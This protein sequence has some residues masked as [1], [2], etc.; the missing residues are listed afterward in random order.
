L[1]AA[2][3]TRRTVT[4]LEAAGWL[5]QTYGWTLER[6]A[7]V[8]TIATQMAPGEKAEPTQGGLVRVWRQGGN[9]LIEDRTGRD[10]SL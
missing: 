7:R 1:T 8:L 3:A 5:A 10:I 2:P 6:A 4:S 9:Y